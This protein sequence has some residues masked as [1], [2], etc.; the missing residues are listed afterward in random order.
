MER[1]SVLLVI[2]LSTLAAVLAVGAA[3]A[4][5]QDTSDGLSVD[6]TQDDDGVPTV[7]VTDNGTA[8]ENSS[9]AVE[10]VD[11]NDTYEGT[12]EY[13]TD[14]NGTVELVAPEENV[15]VGV[16]ATFDNETATTE[17]DLIAVEDEN[18]SSFGQ[19]VSSFVNSINDNETD[20]PM[21]VLVANFVLEN[22]PAADKIPDHAGPPENKTGPPENKTGP[23]ENKTGPP[24]EKG[25]DGD[26]GP[27]EN[28][29]PGDDTDSTEED[30]DDSGSQ[31]PPDEA[32]R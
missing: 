13:L 11:E 19:A 6:V 20:G 27:P 28:A 30:E 12:G 5:A 23:P 8:V 32:G 3:P 21:G 17:A 7:N 2:A 10:T 22:N 1:K 4:A 15:T 25:P 31:G 16:T 18:E 26:N 29:G 24:E 14:E 9:V